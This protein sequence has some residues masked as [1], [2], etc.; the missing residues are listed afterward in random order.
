M[1]ISDTAEYGCYLF[2]Q[3]ARPL[4][5]DFV[6]GLGLDAIGEGISGSNA[7]DNRTLIEV[8]DAIIITRWRLL[9]RNCAVT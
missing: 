5:K 3:A 7:V 6:A 2:D 4:L 8:N 1:V 9:A